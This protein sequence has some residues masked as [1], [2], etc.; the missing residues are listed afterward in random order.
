MYGLYLVKTGAA[1][2]AGAPWVA[3]LLQSLHDHYMIAFLIGLILTLLVQS[4][5]AIIMIAIALAASGLFELEETAMVMYGAQAGTGILTWIFSFHA[6]GRAR[7]V[8]VTQIAFDIIATLTVVVLFYTEIL[9]GLPMISA[10]ARTLS[11]ET[12]TQAVYVALIFQFGSAGISVL[13]R[14]P[15]LEKIRRWFPPSAAE[16]LAEAKFLRKHLT[17]S[18]ETA[19]L[20]IEK[21]QFRLLKR[22]PRYID[23]VRTGPGD[24]RHHPQSFHDAFQQ[25]SARI[26]DALSRI[27]GHGLNQVTSDRLIRTT[28]LN[29]QLVTLE[30]IVYRLSNQMLEQDA[31]TR[32]GKLGRNI[33]EGVDFMILSAIDALVSRDA[34]EIETLEILTHDRSDLMTRIRHA[35]F[36]SEKDLSQRERNFVLDITILFEN[37]VQTLGRYGNLL[38]TAE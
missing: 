15:V 36:D 30:D 8:V 10:L 3:P 21:E 22:L 33:M 16:V 29:E 1:G 37:A 31:D 9:T 7:Q 13:I 32:A 4:N 20:L 28:K 34:G 35:Y 18:P 6:H 2:F 11:A 19:L 17:D 25:I 5:L 23:F 12:G 24:D 26:G 14:R 27:S 38:R